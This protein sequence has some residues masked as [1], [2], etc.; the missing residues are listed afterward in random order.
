VLNAIACEWNSPGRVFQLFETDIGNRLE[1]AESR[2][3]GVVFT[4]SCGNRQL[5]FE[6]DPMVLRDAAME[7]YYNGGR[8][9]R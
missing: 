4:E 1:R 8:T 5:R 2:M 3:D 7:F 6:V 9:L